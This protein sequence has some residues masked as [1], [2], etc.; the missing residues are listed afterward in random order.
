MGSKSQIGL[1]TKQSDSEQTPAPQPATV[2]G[3]RAPPGSDAVL[4]F[5]ADSA[6]S[7]S[8]AL[9]SETGNFVI[10]NDKTNLVEIDQRGEEIVLSI[11]KLQAKSLQFYGDLLYRDIPQWKLVVNENYWQEPVGWTLNTISTCGG[12]QMLG[13]YS[14]ISGSENS[15]Q[16][17]DLPPHNKV[18]STASFHF[19]DAWTGETGYMKVN[20]GREH[21]ME[22]VWTERYDSTK[23]H[24]AINVCGA[25][26]GE[27]KF[28][29][30][31]DIT[32]PHIENSITILF[33]STLDQD[34]QTES[35]GVSNL[36]I[37]IM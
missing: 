6:G 28:S 3:I 7:V 31:I 26:Y 27:G 35:W 1:T 24:N 22:Y 32:V 29:S 19:I 2:F 36:N 20:I 12:I 21:A 18:R 23:S 15:K 33:G 4:K 17:K 34:P 9:L 11:S 5:T 37:Y 14:I 13:G 8:L 30:A 16:F 10:R 25:H